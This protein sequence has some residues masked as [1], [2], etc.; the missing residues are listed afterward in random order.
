MERIGRAPAR[1][2]E[3]RENT[4]RSL[5]RYIRICDTPES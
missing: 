3:D 5:S 4:D 2:Q 1:G